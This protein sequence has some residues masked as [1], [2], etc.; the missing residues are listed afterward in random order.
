MPLALALAA[1]LAAATALGS[2]P[3]VPAGPSQAPAQAL[4]D[5]AARSA[6]ALR[7]YPAPQ[8]RQGVAVGAQFLYAVSNHEIVKYDKH[9]GER[10]GQWRG[11]PQRFPHI[12][13]C[14]LIGAGVTAFYM[15]RLMLMTFAGDKRW[16][17]GVHPH[18]S[19]LT[20]TIP[21][22]VLGAASVVGGIVLNGWI[23]E[24]LNPAVQGEAETEGLIHPTVIG[25]VTMAVVVAGI[26]V[27]FVFF[28][29][30]KT[31]ADVQPATRSPFVRAGRRDLYGDAVCKTVIQKN[32]RLDEAASGRASIFDYDP[33]SRGAEN[34]RQLLEEV[35]R[36]ADA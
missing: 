22:I 34:Y 15:T 2:G 32:V 11:D 31:I 7:R 3:A 20:M 14:A 10:L 16:R 17:K 26:A 4:A 27:S 1:A 35:L 21:L 33:A 24:W 30:Q 29:P 36:R 18:E 12:N 25:F 9:S 19:P 6:T 13:S 5:A 28:G 23:A 8:A